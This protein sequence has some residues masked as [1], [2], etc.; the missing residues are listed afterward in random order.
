MFLLLG[1]LGGLWLA[2]KLSRRGL[3]IGSFAVLALSMAPM[4]IW[5][6]AP[7]CLLFPR[8]TVLD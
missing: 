7:T 6:S 4:A 5:P 1:S 3:T 8:G 2:A